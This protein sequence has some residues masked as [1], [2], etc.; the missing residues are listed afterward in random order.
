MINLRR[1][2]RQRRQSRQ[3]MLWFRIKIIANRIKIIA[4]RIKRI[5]K[6]NEDDKSAEGNKTKKVKQTEDIMV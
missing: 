5:A 2:T 1:G 4:N 6:A 3:R